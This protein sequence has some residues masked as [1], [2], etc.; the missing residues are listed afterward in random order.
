MLGEASQGD[1]GLVGFGAGFLCRAKLDCL[2]LKGLEMAIMTAEV[3][4]GALPLV[5]L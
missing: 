5:H 2:Y 4:G 1:L 3:G